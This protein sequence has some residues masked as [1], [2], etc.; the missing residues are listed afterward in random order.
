[1]NGP[2]KLYQTK[3]IVRHDLAVELP[4]CMYKLKNIHESRSNNTMVD[5]LS[6]HVSPPKKKLNI[7]DQVKTLLKVFNNFFYVLSFDNKFM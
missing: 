6:D 7:L 5:G 1:M 4:K 3:Q 2:V